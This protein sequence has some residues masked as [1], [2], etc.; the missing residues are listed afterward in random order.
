[1]HREKLQRPRDEMAELYKMRAN[2]RVDLKRF[3][4]AKVDYD[5][6][7]VCVCSSVVCV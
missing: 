5:K 4:E 3:E 2:A 1:M 6:V 7:C